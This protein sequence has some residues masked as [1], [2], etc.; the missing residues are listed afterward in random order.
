MTPGPARVPQTPQR[1][2]REAPVP[3]PLGRL[4]EPL[5]RAVIAA[6]NRAFD[7]GRRVTRLPFPV[8]SVGNLSVG[9]TG[10]T[11]MVTWIART[12]AAHGVRP[13]I[14]LR[15][16]MPRARSAA[17]PCPSDE[18][19]V[20]AEQ[21]P[22]V[23]LAVGA[24]RVKS[25]MNLRREHEFDAAILDDGFQHR[26]VARNLDIVLIDSTRDPRADRCL[27]AGRLREPLSSLA[28][29]DVVV[30]T[31]V[32]DP[33]SSVV[34]GIHECIE[35]ALGRPIPFA[36][37]GHHWEALRFPGR[38]EPVSRLRDMRIVALAAIG[39]PAAFIRQ[40]AR[41]G[42]AVSGS[43]IRRDHHLW[44]PGDLDELRARILEFAPID[45]V[46]TTEKD[47]VKL[48]HL[49]LSALPVPVIRPM[50]GLVFHQGEPE[51]ITRILGAAA[52]TRSEAA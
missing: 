2:E 15:G 43:L 28:R 30:Y 48:R 14:A 51:L 3:A 41:A 20:Y 27:P 32:D 9:G 26:F 29:A 44:R 34:P 45:A 12:L 38:E 18:A 42:A 6:R 40:A 13:A 25:L 39:N 23:P 52:G 47:W 10:K 36:T 17:Q 5:Y 50:L 37:C 24:N 11:P 35:R 21:L 8:I 46:L 7:R 19:A 31:R 49:D 33:A 16:Y 4:I 1:V 22:G